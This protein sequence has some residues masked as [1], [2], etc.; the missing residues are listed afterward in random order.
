[1]FSKCSLETLLLLLA[2]DTVLR[3]MSVLTCSDCR[4]VPQKVVFGRSEA[5]C[6]TGKLAGGQI[7]WRTW[8]SYQSQAWA[9]QAAGSSG[10]LVLVSPR[11]VDRDACRGQD[12]SLRARGSR[13]EG[14]S[15]RKLRNTEEQGR[16]CW[17][18]WAG[19]FKGIQPCLKGKFA[20]VLK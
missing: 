20:K 7:R 15:E 11:D 10:C 19:C 3:E 1:M 6:R 16:R 18:G 13:A 4:R 9:V 14:L 17:A 8:A 5:E 12:T 2:S